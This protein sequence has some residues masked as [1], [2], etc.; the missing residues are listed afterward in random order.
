M[1]II[2]L[3]SGCGGLDYGLVLAGHDIVFANDIDK[4]AISTYNRNIK[5]KDKA[6]CCDVF[7][8][9]KEKLPSADCIV[10]GFPCPSF[11]V[12]NLN[13]GMEDP[14]SHLYLAFI[15]ALN[16]NKIPFFLLENVQGIESLEKGTALCKILQDFENC[17][18][19]VIYNIFN[20]KYF[21][22][23]Q[24]RPRAIIFGYNREI[25]DVDVPKLPKEYKNKY[26]RLLKID[27]PIV[28]IETMSE[29]IGDLPIDYDEKIPNHTGSICKVKVKNHLGNRKTYWDK[30]SPAIMGRGSGSGGPLIHPHPSGLRRLSCRECARIQTFPDDFVFEGSNSSVYRQIG[31][32]V[33]VKMAYY[34]GLWLNDL[35]WTNINT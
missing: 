34:L 11:S 15:N 18:Y 32:A 17:G 3:F 31:N 35:K 22:V 25:V 13:R 16:R 19:E 30:P 9:V 23:P 1:R 12:A 20:A 26:R 28:T 24:N 10:G 21:G 8:A 7:D 6:I 29:A 14:R 33:P 27:Y 2:S 4:D 5:S